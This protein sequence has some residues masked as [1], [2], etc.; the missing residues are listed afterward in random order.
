MPTATPD[1]APLVPLVLTFALAGCRAA[2][3][4]LPVPAACEL[5]AAVAALREDGPGERAR[6]ALGR[7]AALHGWDEPDAE[8]YP[9]WGWSRGSGSGGWWSLDQAPLGLARFGIE[10]PAAC[11]ARELDALA[12]ATRAGLGAELGIP[13]LACCSYAA[14]ALR[15]AGRG[16]DAEALL[17]AAVAGVESLLAYE[18]Q[19][20]L[21]LRAAEAGDLAGAKRLV[22]ERVLGACM[23]DAWE[24]VLV[25]LCR[26]AAGEREDALLDA[27]ASG[28]TAEALEELMELRAARGE[29]VDPLLL[30][31]ELA[32]RPGA[33]P[34][35][36]S[37][38][39][40]ASDWAYRDAFL[41]AVRHRALLAIPAEDSLDV[42]P[43]LA[44]DH[45]REVLER[46]EAL[47]PD[48][49]GALVPRWREGG[50]ALLQVL[51]LTGDPRVGPAVRAVVPAFEDERDERD[52]WSRD[53]V[54][55][56]RLTA[57]LHA[58][59]H[60]RDTRRELAELARSSGR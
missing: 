46:L 47:G 52:A 26:E 57:P 29:R 31:E 13:G 45:P 37:G 1:S 53:H 41:R 10:P 43:F 4:R 60:A 7:H 30:A 21:A 23:G 35:G 50:L 14:Q 59:T 38:A 8:L 40:G 11:D 32:R 12:A 15:A 5:S 18:L 9:A 54:R 19:S 55:T 28:V 2:H 24:P 56:S 27:L 16:A 36:A 58:W 33:R 6:A 39:S 48:A 22:E 44:A 51:A 49:V 42:L 25:E 17:R 34:L 3:P 20:L